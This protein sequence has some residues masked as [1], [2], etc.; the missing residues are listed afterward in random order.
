MYIYTPSLTGQ[1]V[2]TSCAISAKGGQHGLNG[3]L[4]AVLPG[5]NEPPVTLG[6]R[7]VP[8]REHLV[9]GVDGRMDVLADPFWTDEPGFI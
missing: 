1:I 5:P 7:L 9:G 8:E 6:I 3:L 2:K 4:Q